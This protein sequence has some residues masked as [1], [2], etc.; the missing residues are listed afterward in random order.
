M[1]KNIMKDGETPRE[2]KLENL[3][4]EEVRGFQKEDEN[5]AIWDNGYSEGVHWGIE[6]TILEITKGLRRSFGESIV[7]IVEEGMTERER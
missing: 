4:S 6:L 5:R 3:D 7:S 2:Q 1:E